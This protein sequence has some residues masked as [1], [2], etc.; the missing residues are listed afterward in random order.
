LAEKD[1]Y[2]ILGVPRGA[3]KDQI[4]DAYRKLALQFHPDRNKSP[5]AEEKFKEISEAY[6]VLSDDEKRRQYD[7]YGKEGFYQRYTT[8]DI[9]RGADFEDI[10]RGMGFGGFGGFDDIFA[11]FFGGGQRQRVNRG[12]DLTYHLQLNLDDIVDDF[13]QEIEVR[14]MEI[15]STCNG[16]GSKQGTSP[17]TCG[18]CGGTG[19]VQRVQTAG[20]ARLVRVTTCPKCGGR[21]QVVD[22]PCKD[23]RGRG[24]R[25]RARKISVVIPAGVED[26][27]TLRLRGEGNAGENGSPPGDLYLVVDVKPHPRFRREDGDVYI[28]TQVGAVEAMLGSELNVPTLYGEVRLT[29]PPGT[30]PG[31]LFKIR[32]KGLPRLGG[33]GK[34]DEYVR[35]NVAIPKSLS[36]T[37]RELLKK[38]VEEGHRRNL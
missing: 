26:G 31:Q 38:F 7:A 8:E 13:T 4:K 16:S 15:C 27:H 1:F 3:T 28:E 18:T 32:E 11:Q 17:R 37:Q 20:F 22:S 6:A 2:S 14:R 33:H 24:V 35:V 25:E 10:F 23:C 12:E 34:G 29:I 36:G 30:Q 5:E 21:G 9:F 19:Q